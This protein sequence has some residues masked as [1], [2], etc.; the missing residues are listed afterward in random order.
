[1]RKRSK[2]RTKL[3]TVTE[4]TDGK[5]NDQEFLESAR[6]RPQDFT[7][8]RKLPFS[9]L[10]L[11]MLN[12]IKGST[13]TCLDRYFEM[14]GQEE[15]HMAQQSFSEAREKIKWEAFQDL[16]KT[17]VNVIYGAYYDTWHG[18]RLSAIDGSKTQL[19]DDPMLREYFGTAGKGKSSPTAQSS[20]LYD[21]LNGFLID[22]QIE[23]M[24]TGERELALRH[25]DELCGMSS[26]DKECILFDRGYASFDLIN[27]LKGRG[28]SFVMR[29]RR[30]FNLDIDR[31]AEGDNSSILKKDGFDDIQ[32]RVLKFRLS[33][34]E[35]ETLITDI[36]DNSMGVADFKELYFKRWPIETK[37]DELKNKLEVE[38]FS[39]RTV[40]AIRQDFF[41]TMYMSNVI[42][43]AYWE[44]QEDVDEAREQKDNK[45][46]YH[47][48]V[49]NAIGTFK[50]R[51]ILAILESRS[52]RRSK[53][54]KRII[55]LMTEQ[56]VPTRPDR[57]LPR[58]P[59]PRKSKFHHNRKSNC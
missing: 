33:S 17:I 47:V 30:K 25:I 51:F 24:A 20:A 12:M 42:A 44:A 55:Y 14:T 19:P 13:Q 18:Y 41:I 11:F 7:R 54:V 9:G 27:T 35:E 49:S 59:S 56:V 23:P 36:T 15:I 5:I 34:G 37:F 46:E 4:Q 48:N 6:K 1:M 22:A 39:G 8:K 40:N 21:V 58:N 16:Y 57:S 3:V 31:L 38:N 52:R 29:V 50:D 45:Y 2:E 43:V 32:V 26:F 10:I 53:K 28:I